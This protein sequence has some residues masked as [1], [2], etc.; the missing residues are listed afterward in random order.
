MKYDELRTLAP[1]LR[2]TPY[3]LA[4]G[5]GVGAGARAKPLTFLTDHQLPTTPR[6]G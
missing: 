3:P 5:D 6:T 1:T 2:P 4:S